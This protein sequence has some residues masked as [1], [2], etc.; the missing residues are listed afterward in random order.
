[1]TLT[2]VCMSMSVS[3]TDTPAVDWWLE[4]SQNG[5]PP[6]TKDWV[7][8][9]NGSVASSLY[10]LCYTLRRACVC[11]RRY[12]RRQLAPLLGVSY[13][14]LFFSPTLA[15]PGVLLRGFPWASANSPTMRSMSTPQ[16]TPNTFCQGVG[17]HGQLWEDGGRR[18]TW[19]MCVY[20]N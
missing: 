14:F 9:V 4:D 20:H 3:C 6:L 16:T 2:S 12:I 10:A 18:V 15:I 13:F 11:L 19:A 8:I 5:H 1:M 17:I 7:T